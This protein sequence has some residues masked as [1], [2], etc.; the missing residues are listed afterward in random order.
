MATDPSSSPSAGSP[1]DPTRTIQMSEVTTGSDIGPY[2]LV[3]QLGEGGMGVVYQARQSEPIRRDVALKVIK[4]GM[5]SKQVIAR[6]ESE[7]QA[8]ALMDHPNIAHVFDTGTTPTGR[9]YFVMELVDGVPITRYCDSK[10][11]TVRERLELFIPVCQAIQH[12]HQKGII[13][14]DIKPSNIVV[15][16]QE[17]QAVPKVID[18]G[19]AKALGGQLTDATVM[20]NL[21]TVVGTFQYMSPEQAEIGRH[22]IDTRSDV[23]SL[24][25]VLYELLTGTTPLDRL[26]KASYVEVLQ[27]IREEETKPPSLRLRRSAELK[28]TAELRQ[29]DPA[30]LPKLIDHELDWI[31]M[32]A[33]E[34]DRT[35]RFETVNGLTRDLQRYLEGEPVD[36]APPSAAYRFSKLVRKYRAWLATAAAFTL[37]LVTGIVVSG[38]MAVRASR[39]EQ[40]ARAVNDFLRNDLLA[41]ASAS[42]QARPDARPDANLT[43]RTALDRAAANIAGKFEKQPLVE[44]SI[45]Q[46][47]GDTYGDLGLYPEAQRQVERAL[48]LRRRLLGEGHPDTLSSMSSLV[49]VY[50]GQGRYTQ[51]EQLATKL[52]AGRRHVLGSEHPD[53]IRSMRILA[54]VHY[55]QGKYAQAEPL[56]VKALGAGRR[57]WGEEHDD[58]LQLMD[59]LAVTYKHEAKYAQAEPL[60]TT[61]LEVRR[62]VSGQEHPETLQIMNDLAGLYYDQGKYAQAEPLYITALDVRRRVLGDEHPRTLQSM[63]NMAL[64]YVA[65]GKYAQAERLYDRALEIRHRV[66]GAGHL[67]TLLVMNNL[68]ELYGHEGRY[69]KA[70]ALFNAT[71]EAERRALGERHELTLASM[72]GL[73]D[74]YRGQ[75]NYVQAESLQAKVLE[76]QSR[77]MGEEHPDTLNT[78]ASLGRTRLLEQKYTEAESALRGALK[79]YEKARPDT[80]E[81]FSCQNLLGASL[82]GQK[83]FAEAEPLLVSSYDEMLKRQA[84]IP[85]GERSPLAEAC[86]RIVQLYRDWGKPEKAAEWKEKLEAVKTQVSQQ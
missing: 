53:T 72:S 35:R 9:P 55:L 71:L 7:R 46:T 54:W 43:V 27:R 77:V 85:R 33:L 47:I 42:K 79:T 73:A 6:F 68:A 14:R 78:F 70:E 10:R 81:R 51:A 50:N 37:L 64:L 13:H 45:R 5:D 59:D 11:L 34:K 75:G 30:R 32:K 25:A 69:A 1:K 20:T 58:T 67:S 65:R 62:R 29:S 76:L 12:A 22:D 84:T 4:P 24:G 63:N 80:W 66:S 18:F 19:L 74:A 41:Q 26:E 52:L 48:D 2:H 8:L 21:G 40:E 15:K 39:A 28:N 17:N 49:V 44:A 60:Y 16:Q 36:A 82:T 38:W 31:A 57:I 23:Y 83:R 3:R 61:A 86:E 56:Q